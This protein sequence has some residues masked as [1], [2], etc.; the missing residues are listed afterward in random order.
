[1]S[2][3][4]DFCATF[5]GSSCDY[6]LGVSLVNLIKSISKNR[7]EVDHVENLMGIK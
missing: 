3:L 1:M 6:E 2:V 5:Q 4:L 7:L